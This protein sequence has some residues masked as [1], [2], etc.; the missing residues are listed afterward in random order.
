MHR[1]ITKLSLICSPLARLSLAA[2]SSPKNEGTHYR[3][4]VRVSLLFSVLSLTSLGL[5]AT[6]MAQATT[7]TNNLIVP[8]SLTL[9]PSDT[10]CVDEVIVVDGTLHV[11]DRGTVD[12]RGGG[13]RELRINAQGLTGV[14]ET[15]GAVYRVSGPGHITLIDDQLINE[16]DPTAPVRV[17]T[18]FDIT[19]VIGPGD[20][21]NLMVRSL[22]HITRNAQGEVTASV[23]KLSI[24]CH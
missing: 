12:A 19:H 20:L 21:I 1:R 23:D 16:D 17:A 4:I 14:G 8:F 5:P 24:E 13:H 15:S 18:F 6:T 2:F 3:R 7:F 9:S 10:P 22:T 11:V